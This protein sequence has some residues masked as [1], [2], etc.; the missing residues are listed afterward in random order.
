[1][2]KSSGFSGS[3][4]QSYSDL[5]E[6]VT[7]C[8][9]EDTCKAVS[10]NSQSSPT[11]HDTVERIFEENSYFLV[12]REFLNGIDLEYMTTTQTSTPTSTQTTSATSTQTTS[13]TT[14]QTSTLTSTQ[15]STLTSTQTTTTELVETVNISDT[16]IAILVVV[17]VILSIV[18][19]LGII[20]YRKKRL[21]SSRVTPD[22][23]RETFSNPLYG[24]SEPASIDE[25]H[26]YMDVFEEEQG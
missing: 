18:L 3:M 19:P 25:N 1:M 8:D 6:T 21:Y 20:H 23:S 9:L 12:K 15:T 10:F 2:N 16:E 17:L 22:I 24:V 26:N 11:T 14:T 4:I 13:A 7:E 5:N